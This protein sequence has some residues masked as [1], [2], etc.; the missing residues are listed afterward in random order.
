MK[1]FYTIEKAM[2]YEWQELNN[3]IYSSLVIYSVEMTT[4]R[5]V[6]NGEFFCVQC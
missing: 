6:K 1:Y 3:F 5:E 4:M 2:K